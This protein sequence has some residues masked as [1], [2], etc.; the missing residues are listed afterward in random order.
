MI[1]DEVIE[2]YTS[3]AEF[4]RTHGNLQGCLEFR[5]LVKWLKDYK[6]LLEQEPK[7]GHWIFHEIEDTLRWY[8]CDQ[9][10][11]SAVKKYKFCSN[12]GTRMESE[13]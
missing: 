8:E 3:N 9:C 12:C 5:Q 7:T 13:E 2:K 4:E 1:L 6:R 11:A 10:G